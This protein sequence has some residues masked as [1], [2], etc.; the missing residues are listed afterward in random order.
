MVD[1][2]KFLQIPGLMMELL[3]NISRIPTENWHAKDDLPFY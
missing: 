1:V 2:L 3:A